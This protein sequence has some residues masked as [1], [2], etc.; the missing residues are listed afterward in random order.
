MR[1]SDDSRLIRTLVV[2]DEAI[3][4]QGL[5]ALVDAAP[6]FRTVG[7]A[8]GGKQAVQMVRE[9]KP[10]VVFLDVDMPDLNGF[11]VLD[12][13]T[14]DTLPLVVF[15]TAYD[16]F[17][18]R[19]FEADAVDYLL[20]PFDRERLATTL[21]RVRRRATDR[22]RRI[23]IRDGGRLFFLQLS[24]IVVIEA[25]GNYVRLVTVEGSHL[26][27]GS[28]ASLQGRL[29]NHDFIRISRSCVVNRSRVRAVKPAGGGSYVLDL[30]G[31]VRVESSRRFRSSVAEA[32]GIE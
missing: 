14:I 8:A 6:G 26:V 3:A 18:I 23:M 10:D 2:D 24:E 11:Q 1:G 27:R 15:V 29:P 9:L 22:A 21:D 13:L 19:A 5:T 28:I 32:F 17:A 25:A 7:A 20:K 12:A 30:D 31:G 4:R 16:E